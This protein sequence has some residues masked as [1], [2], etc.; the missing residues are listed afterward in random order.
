MT[1]ETRRY[2]LKYQDDTLAQKKVRFEEEE[3][4]GEETEENG[5]VTEG[6]GPLTE[7]NPIETLM[8]GDDGVTPSQTFYE[9]V[10]KDFK[11]KTGIKVVLP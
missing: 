5:D 1:L 11:P 9:R 10:P 8:E 6:D 3:E 4:D 7:A 2:F